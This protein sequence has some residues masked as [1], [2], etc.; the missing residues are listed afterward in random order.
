MDDTLIKTKSGAKFAKDATDWKWW[1]DSIIPVV[2]D[3]AKKGYQIVIFT[4][5]N[6][7]AKGHTN[8]M[9]VKKKIEELQRL[10]DVPLA[11]LIASSDDIYRKPRMGNINYYKQ[12]R[13][14]EILL[15]KPQ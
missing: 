13:N 3:Y 4:N 1:H 12:Y 5:Q 9:D 7:I 6:G 15:G 8:E 2:Q 14:V 11:A 10:L